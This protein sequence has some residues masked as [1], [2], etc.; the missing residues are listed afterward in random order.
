MAVLLNL[1]RQQQ[2]DGGYDIDS[3]EEG[4]DLSDEQRAEL[5]RAAMARATIPDS[6]KKAIP[7]K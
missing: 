6:S 1:R 3:L 5:E 4:Q 7:S 2:D